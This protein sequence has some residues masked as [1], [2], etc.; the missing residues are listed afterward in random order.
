MYRKTTV[1]SPYLPSSRWLAVPVRWL[2]AIAIVL[3]LW[4]PLSPAQSVVWLAWDPACR[5]PSTKWA[6]EYNKR[7]PKLQMRYL[8][9]G[10]SE[11]INQV[12]HGSGDFG[13]GEVPLDGCLATASASRST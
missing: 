7:D 9:L 13:A 11:G 8:A 2:T 12:A 3:S 5:F 1:P 4:Q 10:T 6:Q